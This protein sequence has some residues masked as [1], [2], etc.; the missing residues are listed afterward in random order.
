MA[1]SGSV[2]AFFLFE[3]AESTDLSAVRARLGDAA[4]AA[5][6]YD[7][8]AGPPGV[9]YIQPPIVAAADA[10]GVGDIGG[11]RARVKFYDYGVISLMLSREFAGSWDEL[12]AVSQDLIEN[13]TLEDAAA[14]ACQEV[15]ERARTAL[16]GLRPV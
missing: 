3:V 2:H 5:T 12:A 15:V 6:L 10:L 1:V 9:R 11:F 13:D 14:I 16:V 4:V 8:A 7:K